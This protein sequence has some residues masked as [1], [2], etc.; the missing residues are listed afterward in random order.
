MNK[1]SESKR[2]QIVA[3][4]VE[5]NSVRAT[6][7]MTGAAKGTVLKL[8]K[9]L[10]CACWDYQNR[11]LVNLSC[12]RLQC[13]EIWAFCYAKQR[14]V[15]KAK[16]APEG[17][18]DVWAWTA[19]CA[20]CKLVPAFVLGSRDADAALL[21]M[22][23]LESRLQHRIQLTTDGHG[24]YLSA[25]SQAFS[26]RVDYAQLVKHYGPAPEAGS[27]TRYSPAQ[28]TGCS[29]RRVSG[30]PDPAHVSTSYVERQ[31]LTMRMSMRRFTR[32]TNGFSKKVENL[33][34]ALALHYMHYNFARVHKSLR[35]TPAMEA[36][37]SDHVW[38]LEEIVALL[39]TAE[40][41]GSN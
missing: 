14:N 10:G 41:A 25:V 38:S 19:I 35:V 26:G 20:D 17:A 16:A 3:P 39:D 37:I 27:E 18:G 33:H 2:V 23:N 6:C 40:L 21:F 29:T 22:E 11:V 7:R 5:G 12:K 28:C 9:D 36:G 8:L 32:L 15:A 4:L 30:D 1:L 31:N 34:H 24:A 13:D